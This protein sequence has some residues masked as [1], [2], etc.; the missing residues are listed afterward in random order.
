MAPST[1]HELGDGAVSNENENNIELAC[2]T[3]CH[4]GRLTM[5]ING[6]HIRAV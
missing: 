6:M 3:G 5:V 4:Q 2:G 1:V